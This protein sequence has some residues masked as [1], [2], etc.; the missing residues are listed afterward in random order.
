MLSNIST[1]YNCWILFNLQSFLAT[2]P[3]LEH[4]IYNLR[5]SSLKSTMKKLWIIL[6][7]AHTLTHQYEVLVVV[8]ESLAPYH[9]C[10]KIRDLTWA[11]NPFGVKYWY[12]IFSSPTAYTLAV[13]SC[14]YFTVQL[15]TAW[16]V[17]R[18]SR[19]EWYGYKTV[20]WVI[21]FKI[22]WNFWII[23]TSTYWFFPLS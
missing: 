11:I 19:S 22:Q 17:F 7:A 4:L 20:K 9:T 8:W 14:L 16:P 3:N 1:I 12:P 6:Q 23:L 13:A 15:I 2:Q 18:S 5:S 21:W 10:E